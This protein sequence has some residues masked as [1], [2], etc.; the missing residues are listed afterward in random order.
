MKGSASIQGVGARQKAAPS[1]AKIR[2]KT[3]LP[4]ANQPT[5]NSITVSTVAAMHRNPGHRWYVWILGLGLGLI[6][7]WSL[8]ITHHLWQGTTRSHPDAVLMLG[9]S[10]RREMYLAEQVAQ[11][12]DIP[13]LI[14]RGSPDPCIRILFDRAAAPL[15]QVWLETCAHSTFD[16]FRYGWPTLRGWRVRRVRVV[17]SASHL[18]RARWLAQ[19]MLGSHGI[20]VEMAIVPEQGVPG[21][22]ERP[23]KTALDVAR[24]FG[25]ALVSQVYSPPCRA[26]TPLAAV[27]LAAWAGQGYK[28]EHQ[29]GIN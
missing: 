11:G 17:T 24:A 25:W 1:L 7:A 23:I 14:S 15:D 20:W 18:P 4:H 10:I 6:L 12:L 19:V 28:C 27:D 5:G 9:G 8:P 2:G 22:Q 29:G 3:H 26:I 21:N 16:N 13:I